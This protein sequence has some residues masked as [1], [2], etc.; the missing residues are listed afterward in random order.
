MP[1]SRPITFSKEAVERISRVVRDVERGGRDEPPV[2]FSRPGDE[3]EAV[4]LGTISATWFKGEDA[5]VTQINGDG[6]AISPTVEFT[7]KNWF[8]SVIVTTGTKKVA[9]AKVGEWWLLIA[10]E[11]E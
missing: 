3:D 2:F 10:A 11:C 9:C 5:T 8:S 7:A 1:A 4:R 6:S